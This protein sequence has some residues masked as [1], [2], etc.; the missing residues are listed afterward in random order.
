MGAMFTIISHMIIDCHNTVCEDVSF[1][2]CGVSSSAQ[3][4]NSSSAAN[5]HKYFLPIS[6]AWYQSVYSSSSI[7]LK[8]AKTGY[9]LLGLSLH[10]SRMFQRCF[11]HHFSTQTLLSR[12][13]LSSNGAT[14]PPP[15]W[16]RPATKAGQQKR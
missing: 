13:S 11:F 12:P 8:F 15:R 1:F 6:V 3:K 4:L 7:S 9:S 5:F 10:T 2:W 14:P 16:Q